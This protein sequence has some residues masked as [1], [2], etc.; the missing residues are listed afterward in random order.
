LTDNLT[1]THESD[2]VKAPRAALR[3]ALLLGFVL[4]AVIHTWPLASRPGLYTRV[5]NADYILNVWAVDWVA[6]TLPTDPV[7]LF[8]AN[9]FHPAPR[10][11]AYSEPLIL[12]GAL[13][14]PAY[15][16]GLDAVTTFNLV[17][18][19]GFALSAGRSRC[20]FTTTPA[21]GRRGW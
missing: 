20:W 5:D 13:A 10:T 7:H 14:M 9:I 15:W 8:D 4:L 11:L 21:A 3:A 12:Q 19:A 2:P 16:L 17:L 18:I 6:R 1:H